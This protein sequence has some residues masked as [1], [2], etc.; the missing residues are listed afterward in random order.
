MQPGPATHTA[1]SLYTAH[2]ERK[3][4]SRSERFR[5]LDAAA[6]L[7]ADRALFCL[8]LAWTGARISEVLALRP[9]DLQ[10][11]DCLISFRTLKRRHL[12]VRQVPVPPHLMREFERHYHLRQRQADP[13]LCDT[14]LWLFHRVTAWRIV[15]CVMA[16]AA[17]QGAAACPKGF[18]HGFGAGSVQAGIPITLLQRWLGHARLSTTAIY[19]EVS[20]PE[21]FQFAKRYWRWSMKSRRR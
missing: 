19:T 20:G 8:T 2:G 18:R 4:L 21:E 12:H 17:L 7:P 3:Y 15:K 16:I 13:D 10:F 1:V 6:R 5:A 9:I 11:D 14:R